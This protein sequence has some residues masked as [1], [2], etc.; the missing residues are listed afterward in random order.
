MIV[1][2]F[3]VNGFERVVS[4]LRAQQAEPPVFENEEVV[5]TSGT[6]EIR[7][8]EIVGRSQVPAA[9]P[10]VLPGTDEVVAGS[11]AQHAEVL[12]APIVLVVNDEVLTDVAVEVGDPMFVAAVH[13]P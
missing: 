13:L 12:R 4:L 7:D 6:P 11:G 5:P 9:D 10:V 3:S 8:L 1:D 2:P